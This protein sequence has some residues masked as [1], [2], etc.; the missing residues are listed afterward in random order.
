MR[1]TSFVLVILI[2]FTAG[3]VMAREKTPDVMNTSAST[4]VLTSNNPS[5]V[6]ALTSQSGTYNRIYNQGAIDTACGAEVSDSANDG[7]YYDVLCF[8]VDDEN[9]IELIVDANGTSG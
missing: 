9:P 4:I 6:G 2:L 1:F 7:M 3:T 8:Q 5:V